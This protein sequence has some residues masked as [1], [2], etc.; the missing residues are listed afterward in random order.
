MRF[1]SLLLLSVFLI[2]GCGDND[3]ADQAVSPAP[4]TAESP[5]E[6]SATMID[7]VQVVE[8]EAGALGFS[9]ESVQL[10][11]GVPARLVFQRT[12]EASCADHVSV[13]AFGVE[14]MPLPMNEEVA[15]E[16]TP[17]EAGEF[18]FVCGMDMQSGTLVVSA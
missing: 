13:P 8:I 18:T 12:T 17:D 9:P 6:I 7:G 5:A 15:V 1:I 2:A 11:A 10:Q 4:S 14:K 3:D 16:F